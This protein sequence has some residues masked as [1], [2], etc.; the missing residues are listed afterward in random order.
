MFVREYVAPLGGD[1]FNTSGR[2]SETILLVE[3]DTDV[4]IATR[5]LLERMGYHVLD[6]GTPQA[7]I[8]LAVVHR[9][10]I[11]MV[12]SDVIMPDMNGPDVVAQIRTLRPRMP[13]LFMSAH[14]DEE[15]IERF[16][17]KGPKTSFI[18]KPF[19]AASLAAKLR[20]VLSAK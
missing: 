15:M 13:V 14:S 10:A 5:R 8:D 17:L 3:D 9:G 6:A 7:A 1:S 19:D 11:D 16:G 20:D 2:G 12:L 18:A 4:R